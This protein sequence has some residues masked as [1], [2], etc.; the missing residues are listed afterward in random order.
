[1]NKK[2]EA[3]RMAI[4]ALEY[5]EFCSNFLRV[6][7]I[8]AC[9]AALEQPTK[10]VTVPLDKLEDMQRRLKA[11]DRMA[12]NV[13]ELGLEYCKHGS[14]S[15][16][17]ECY[18]ENVEQEPFGWWCKGETLDE[19]DYYPAADFPDLDTT[20]CIPLYTR[21]TKPLS[22]DELSELLVTKGETSMKYIHFARAIEKAHGIGE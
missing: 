18:M 21:P 10:M 11:L 12:E 1:M 13:M 16:C 4:E 3:L 15:A 17:K 14:D 9:K 19:S 7:A 22:D 2:D 20:N 5:E 8:N 6:E